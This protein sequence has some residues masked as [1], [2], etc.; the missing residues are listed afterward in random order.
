VIATRLPLVSL[1]VF[2][3]VG[4]TATWIILRFRPTFEYDE[5]ESLAGFLLLLFVPVTIS[6]VLA[7]VPGIRPSRRLTASICAA[8]GLMLFSFELTRSERVDSQALEQAALLAIFP[9]S[10]LFIAARS[11]DAQRWPWILIALGP[12]A[13]WIGISF[14]VFA[15]FFVFEHS[16]R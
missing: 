16:L 2:A 1:S 3:V 12:T 4:T 11:R 13:Y 14:A 7:L 9:A 5:T 10:G 8:V 15:S 6:S